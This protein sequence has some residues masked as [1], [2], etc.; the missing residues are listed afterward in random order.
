MFCPPF[1]LDVSLDPVSFLL[2][3]L[4][5]RFVHPPNIRTYPLPGNRGGGEVFSWQSPSR[6][7]A[8]LSVQHL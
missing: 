6:C 4:L 8:Q 7:L 1:R 5:P 3:A 2:L